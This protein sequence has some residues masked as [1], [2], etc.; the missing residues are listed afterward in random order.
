MRNKFN[1]IVT[2]CILGFSVSM[3]NYA[4]TYELGAF[5]GGANYI[6]DVGD[7]Q[8][9]APAGPTF[10]GIAKWNRSTRHSFRLTYL[11]GQII[12]DDLDSK[13]TR[14]LQRGFSFENTLSEVSL[15]VEYT[16][17]EFDLHE[18]SPA[19]APYLYTG[20]TYTWY[21]VLRRTGTLF[22]SVGRETTYAIPMVLGVKKTLGTK[23]LI[24][25][26]VG[27]RYSFSDALDGSANVGNSEVNNVPFGD[28]TNN[29]WYVFTG[30]TFTYAFG[31]K[32]CYCNF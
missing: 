1:L 30:V 23:F 9:I 4:Q 12:A 2:F 7:T 26:E 22:G 5:V 10:G 13:D 24:G 3:Q 21:D 15:G 31:R 20:V 32:P 19:F 14:R 25:L 27:A 28:T 29:D 6:G 16:F 8:F 17:W 18:G 11:V